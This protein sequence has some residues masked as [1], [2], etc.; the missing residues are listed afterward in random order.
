MVSDPAGISP[1]WV[2]ESCPNVP[3]DHAKA[4]VE[5]VKNHIYQNQG[6]T[7][8]LIFIKM[9]PILHKEKQSLLFR[10]R[11]IE[12]IHAVAGYHLQRPGTG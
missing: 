3:V 7:H 1:T 6:K 2:T 8:V 10:E 11:W 5:T 9:N 12:Y 4:F